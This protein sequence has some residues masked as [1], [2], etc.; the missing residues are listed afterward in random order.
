MQQIIVFLI[1]FAAAGYTLLGLY[2]KFKGQ[3]G[4]GCGC[5]GCD[6]E[7]EGD[8]ETCSGLYALRR[9]LLKF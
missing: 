9:I 3:G 5:S 8:K 4:C 1:V 6:G 2:R 7:P